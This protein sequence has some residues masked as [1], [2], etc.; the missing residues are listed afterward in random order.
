MKR[1]AGRFVT[2]DGLMASDTQTSYV[3]A[4]R[5]DLIPE[6]TRAAT[7]RELVRLIA[8]NN[9]HMNTGFVGTPYILEVLERFGH[10]DVAYRL[11]ENETFPSWLFPIKNGA[12]TDLGTLG[13]LDPG[14]RFPDRDDEFVQPLRLRR[15]GRVDVRDSG[16]AGTGRG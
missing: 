13:R 8:K 6:E 9:F 12:T 3:L 5:F 15:G 7:A 1:S 14:E 10:L 4:L 11:L 2:P 16:W